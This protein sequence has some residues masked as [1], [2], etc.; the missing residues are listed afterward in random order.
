MYIKKGYHPW[1]KGLTKETN[2][3]IRKDSESK[4]GLTSGNKDKKHS[5]LCGE[6][7]PANR[8]EV[9]E[10]IRQSKLN[11]KRPDMCGINHFMY[12][13]HPTEESKNKNRIAHIG[14]T[15][16][17]SEEVKEKM[18]GKNHYNWQGGISFEPYCIK[19]N[20]KKREEIRNQYGR[21]CVN[22]GI[23]EKDNITKTGKIRRL[24][25]H[26]V[27]S[28]KDQGCNGKSWKLVPLCIH[29][30]GK[31]HGENEF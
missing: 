23:D 12:G 27:D 3:K 22:C 18:S 10:K 8:P 24:S 31:I 25:V 11:K 30:H 13:K 4:K 6:N 19:F 20:N 14:T 7:N 28:D 1:N 9:K 17:M 29:C 5:H 26:H 21:K 15:H 16:V 2:D